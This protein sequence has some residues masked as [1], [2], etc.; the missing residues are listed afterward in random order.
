VTA[1]LVGESLIVAAIVAFAAARRREGRIPV[2]AVVLGAVPA[3][4]FASAWQANGATAGILALWATGLRL[5]LP[6]WVY[7]ASVWALGATV[8]A[9]TGDGSCR[10]AGLLVLGCAGFLLESTYAMALA[11]VA[12][13]L[14]CGT[15]VR[16]RSA[17]IDV[18]DGAGVGFT[19]A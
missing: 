2:R 13:V 11:L 19:N 9:R 1:Q 10:A 14:L 12:L 5:Y 4:V 6:A 8:V 15:P 7:V 3:L 16:S 17:G 18:S